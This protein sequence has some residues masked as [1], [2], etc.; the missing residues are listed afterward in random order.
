MEHYVW[1]CL[2]FFFAAF[3]QGVSGFGSSLVAMPLLTL[4]IPVKTAVPLCMVNGLFITIYLS[5]KL[6][7][8]F[9]WSK[10]LPLFLAS[11]PGVLIGV[12]I[13]KK[14]APDI[15]K[16]V[17]GCLIIAY[18]LFR[19]LR[20]GRLGQTMRIKAVW[21]WLA[22]FVSGVISAS[23]SAGGPPVVIYTTMTNWHKE[24][25]TSTLSVFFFLSGV[26][27]VVSHA[28]SGFTTVEVLRMD[29][30]SAPVALLGV[31][32]GSACYARID[33][34][35]YLRVMYGLLVVSG[36]FLIYSAV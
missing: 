27:V 26:V 13:L 23:I 15:M 12:Y 25:I 5:F 6:K 10:I 9:D 32:G 28:L 20:R 29:I 30:I 18:C 4:I 33:R 19:F 1:I 16:M 3:T 34:G 31:V 35:T 21:G 14:A 8:H 36:L 24:A 22:G 11:L 17:L 7:E 2:I